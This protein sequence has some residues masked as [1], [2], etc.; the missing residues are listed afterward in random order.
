MLLLLQAP[1]GSRAPIHMEATVCAVPW[2]ESWCQCLGQPQLSEQ[3]RAGQQCSVAAAGTPLSVVSA[4]C[5]FKAA[6]SSLLSPDES[7][8]QTEYEEEVLGSQK[9]EYIDFVS[10][11]VEEDSDS[12]QSALGT[13][14][15]RGK[16]MGGRLHLKG[17]C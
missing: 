4:W 14:V 12:V 17:T 2:L 1:E 9:D 8:Y 13:A 6:F 5:Q 16:G 3:R 15:S 10:G 7:D 11:Q